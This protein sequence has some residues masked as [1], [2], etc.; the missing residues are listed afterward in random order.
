MTPSKVDDNQLLDRLT[1]VFR[2]YGYDGASLSLI[3]EVT[4]LQRASLYHRFPGGKEE[5]ALAVLSKVDHWFVTHILAPLSEPGDPAKRV[6]KMAQRLDKFYNCGRHSCLLDTL[7]L[8]D[9]TK[10]IQQHTQR[11]FN[12][13]LDAL[14]AIARESE[15]KTTMAR[16]R[17][18]D[19]LVQIQG[20]LVFSRTTGDARPF[21]RVLAG[22]PTLLTGNRQT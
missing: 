1:E 14:T 7:S 4:R 19:A 15:V 13:W 3:S 9:A 11:S 2:L 8:S 20:A 10:A 18:A 16:R 17:A 22:L 6:R 21:K 12:A 5:M